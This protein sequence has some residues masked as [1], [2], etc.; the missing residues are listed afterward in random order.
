MAMLNNLV[1]YHY[2]A[3]LMWTYHV[4]PLYIYIAIARFYNRYVW[5]C[6]YLDGVIN[7][8]QN[9][10]HLQCGAPK[11]AKLVNITPITMVHCT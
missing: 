7:Y 9:S 11:I 10:D 5:K 4:T 1:N 3:R 6:L 8:L 2:L